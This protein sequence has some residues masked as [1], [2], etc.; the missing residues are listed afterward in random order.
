MKRFWVT[1]FSLAILA[2]FFIAGPLSSAR[3]AFTATG[4]VSP[5]N[6]SSWT[7]STTAYI[8]NT[9]AGTLTV[10]SGNLLS[11]TG[12]I[13]Y[14]STATGLVNIAG[15]SSTW[16]NSY[17]L[18]VGNSGNGTLKITNGGA[19]SSGTVSSTTDY[20]GCIGY[21]TGSTGV[22]TVDGA[23]ATWTNHSALIVGIFGSGTLKI[24]NGGVVSN[25]YGYIGDISNS[26]G[27]VT[28]DGTGSTWTNSAPLIVGVSGNGTLNITNGGTVSDT[29]GE[30]SWISTSKGTVT[31]DGT[32]SMW[33]NSSSLN[34]GIQATG[35][36]KITN[37]GDVSNTVGYIGNSFGSTGVVTIDGT[38]STWTN[39]GSLSVGSSGTGTL[40][41]INGGA[42][43]AAGTVSVNSMS[44]LAINVGHGSS[45]A[46]GSGAGMIANAGKIRILAG[47]SAAAGT[48]SPISAGTYSGVGTYQ[49]VGGTWS[50]TSHQFT[51]STVTTAASGSAV[52]I[53]LASTQR[54]LVNDNATG[55]AVG[56]SFLATTSASTLTSTATAVS[57]GTLTALAGSLTAGKTVLSGWNLAATTGYTSGTPVYLSLQVGAAQ[58]L[59]DMQVWTY[60]GSSWTTYSAADLTYDRAYA[61]LTVTALG[62][63]AITGD[64]VLT[65]DANRDNSI[66]GAD[67]G[68]VLANFGQSGATWAMGDFNGD[69]AVNGADLGVVLANFNQHVSVTAAVP[70]PGTLTLLAAGLAAIFT[71]ARRRRKR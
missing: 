65:G 8:G 27:A 18:Y 40:N 44:L 37:G 45:L 9:S 46:I 39:S 66:D 29:Y 11:S 33:T 7:S 51:A 70:E 57:G 19:V 15:T 35:T 38:G 55:W 48:Y 16:T 12:Y 59:D 68:A 42:V 24:T 31:V 26:M 14:G 54:L 56:E 32:G 2:A 64:L 52:S 60:S 6:P 1:L 4:N 58:L 10:D 23:G 28:V 5:T 69:G 3:A 20:A 22:V 71:Y 17:S 30:I 62:V 67:L 50:A 63:Y 61:S 13:G 49:A 53:D 47:A 21:N 25:I 41:I 36:L 34:V 43:T